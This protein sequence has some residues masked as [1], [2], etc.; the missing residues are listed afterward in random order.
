MIRRSHFLLTILLAAASPALA[1]DD[2]KAKPADKP[3]AEPAKTA[4]KP[5]TE[6]AKTADKP[7]TDP[8]KPADKPKT[9][10]AKPA[11]KPKEE[12]A[13]TAD[14]PK[15]EPAKPAEKPKE[16]P[17]KTADKPKAEPAK[18]AMKPEAA[19]PPEAKP[20]PKGTVSFLKDVAPIL[21]Q[22]CIACHNPRKA[23]SKYVMTTF[24][25][26]AKGG[27]RGQDITLVA[28]KP[29][30]SY[31]VELIRHDGD[32]RM[33]YKQDPMPLDKIAVIEKWVSEGAAYDGAD[34][35]EDWTFVLRRTAIVQVPE[36]YPVA[37][38]ITALAFAPAGGELIVGGYHELTRWK[39]ADAA[40]AGRLQP[41]S[42]RIYD[43]AF[44][45]DGK[46]LA[47]ASGDPG[48]FGTAKLY[49]VAPDGKATLVKDLVESTD[50]VFAVA[51]SPDGKKLAAAGADRAIRFF[52]VATG[53]LDAT[54]EDHA[55][56]I[57]DIAFSPDGKRLASASRDK[58]AKVFDA[59]KKESLVTFPAHG[60]TVYAVAFSKDGKSVISGGADNQIRVWNPDEDAKQ[61]KNVTGF[62]GPIF[63]L[64]VH[65]DGDRVVAV[66]Q[67]KV[68]RVFDKFA[69]KHAMQGHNDW[70]Y[71]LAL[72]PDG[73]TIA[74]G[75]WD[76]EVRLWTI[77]DGKPVKDF[78]AAPGL[79]KPGAKVSA[80]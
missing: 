47:V 75:S 38:P 15:A 69:P 6:P 42:E 46:K 12:P 33:P 74:T 62:G 67:D 56:W 21:V 32:P 72:S 23:E 65:P 5:K 39:L 17:A 36:S 55:D 25:Q 79:K 68:V 50:C 41:F 70:I 3:K 76:G 64:L 4:E 51:F 40:G 45:P 14:K 80:K 73:K 11:E 52:D 58:T 20:A 31:F 57:F 1:A 71:S 9:D 26:L 66:G 28:G 77:D 53:K 43:I 18:P 61:V 60:D 24:A 44:S 29:D 54:I 27:S 49:D 48:M 2:P 37:V 78:L 59:E 8:A 34:P 35:K 10:P 16:E 22:N 19:K 13:K 63:K 7:K 30:E